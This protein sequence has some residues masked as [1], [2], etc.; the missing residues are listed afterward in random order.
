MGSLWQST[1]K[2]YGLNGSSGS[3]VV[4]ASANEPVCVDLS[5]LTVIDATGADTAEFL[6]G[7]F[8]NDLSTVT[9]NQAQL[10][11]YCTPKGRLLTLAIVVGI[12]SGFRLLV[13]REL[14]AAFVKRLSMFVLRADVTVEVK[15]DY[16]CTGVISNSSGEW[17]DALP[18]A[19]TLSTEPF[20][21][22]TTETNQIIA[23]YPIEINGSLHQRR[24]LIATEAQQL[25]HWQN[26]EDLT[27]SSESIWRYGDI[28]QGIPSLK[29]ETNDSFVPQMVNLQLIHALSFKKGCYPG[30]EIVAR[31]QYLG[32]LK[33]HMRRFVMAIGSDKDNLP[34]AG[35]ALTNQDDENA[36]IV[37]DAVL[38]DGHVELLAVVKVLADAE[39]FAFS[40]VAMS[41]TDLPYNLPSPDDDACDMQGKDS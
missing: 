12:E 32:K 38:V 40:G 3:P 1:M 14:S 19:T 9:A 41:P 2:E 5:D 39:T 6:Q 27:K 4:I 28:Q 8:C 10:T 35:N 23:W 30:Q 15:D 11:G 17:G 25:A 33:R 13:P 16:L 21:A 34:V 20:S 37:V 7:Q 24:I 29:N 18:T 31:M 36:G 26:N 22:T